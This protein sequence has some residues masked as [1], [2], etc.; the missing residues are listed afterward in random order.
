MVGR[1]AIDQKRTYPLVNRRRRPRQRIS[2]QEQLLQGQT[3]QEERDNSLLK[4][5]MQ[6]VKNRNCLKEGVVNKIS[7]MPNLPTKVQI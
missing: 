2:N 1:L 5:I 4:L 3:V 6:R 7:R